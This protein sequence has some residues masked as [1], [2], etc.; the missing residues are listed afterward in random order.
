MEILS[1]IKTGFHSSCDCVNI[2][3]WMHQLDTNE[4]H[5]EEAKWRLCKNVT[6]SC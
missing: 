6:C 2:T 3:V 5:G 1:L 4:V